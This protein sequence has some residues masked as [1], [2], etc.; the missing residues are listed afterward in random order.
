MCPQFPTYLYLI[1]FPVPLSLF[2][3]IRYIFH[4]ISMKF[5]SDDSNIIWTETKTS[6][7]LLLINIITHP[8]RSSLFIYFD[9]STVKVSFLTLQSINITLIEKEWFHYSK[10]CYSVNGSNL[11]NDTVGGFV[12]FSIIYPWHTINEWKEFIFWENSHFHQSKRKWKSI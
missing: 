3:G 2:L 12:V 7:Y 11:N 10:K 1:D 6:Q 8:Y 4:Q 5:N 9:D